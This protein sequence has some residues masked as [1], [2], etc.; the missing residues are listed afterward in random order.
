MTSIVIVGGGTAGWLTAAIIAAKNSHLKHGQN[1][2]QISLIESPDVK[3]LGV[4]EGTWPTMRETLRS[5]GISE[6]ELLKKCNASFKQASKFVNWHTQNNHYYHPFT[7]PSSYGAF[8]LAEHWQPSN[9]QDF[10]DFVCAQSAACEQALAPKLSTMKDYAF[11]LNYGYHL[12]A[13]KFVALLQSHCETVFGVNYIQDHVQGVVND[14]DGYISHLNLKDRGTVEGDM[15]IDCSGF[16]S[17]LIDKHYGIPFKTCSDVLFNDR[18]IAAQ[19]E[20]ADDKTEIASSTIATA[21]SNGWIWDI[22]LQ[23]RRGIGYVYSSRF[24]TDSNAE[25][26]LKRYIEQDP[27][28]ARSDVSTRTIKF[29]PGYRQKFWHKNCVAIGVS[30]GFVEPLEATAMVLI[31]KSAQWVSEQ[32]T[33]DHKAMNVLAKRFNSVTTERWIEIVDFLKLHYVLSDRK[34]S[35]YWCAHREANSIPETLKE[36]LILWR[37]QSPWLYES[38][39]RFELFSS[40]S[41]QFV[42][43]GMQFKTSHQQLLNQQTDT[44]K[45]LNRIRDE[46]YLLKQQLIKQLP[47]NREYLANLS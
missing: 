30:A 27:K 16:T 41:K 45:R 43:Y 23:N 5:I 2:V 11:A 15:F 14:K 47:T 9:E 6:R 32:I 46:N 3:N 24:E 28:L 26:S 7:L 4:G 34:D 31:E 10:A 39:N 35:E 29:T 19:V 21:Q 20:H 33:N 8:N 18:A 13:N 1:A 36:S 22:A 42:L 40:A 37:T 38:M 44:T 25:V 17:I 12:D